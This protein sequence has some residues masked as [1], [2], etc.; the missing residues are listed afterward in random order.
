MQDLCIRYLATCEAI[1]L[2]TRQIVEAMNSRGHTIKA[3]FMSGGLVKNPV[4]MQLL[5]DVCSM[6]VQLPASAS[7]SVVLGSAMLGA[8]AGH[9]DEVAQGPITTQ[10]QASERARAMTHRL[11]DVMV[12]DAT[13]LGLT[14]Q[15]KMS[16]PGTTV[17]PRAEGKEKALLDAK[18]K[19]FVRSV[20][21]GLA[22]L[23]ARAD[24]MP[25]SVAEVD[26]GRVG[27]RGVDGGMLGLDVHALTRPRA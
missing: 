7:A 26:G 5:A 8:A 19:V 10:E 15:V 12:R 25:D 4:L 21:A 6:P 9:P 20:F 17:K 1:A 14:G 22:D 16:R 11:W 13:G 3:I 23:P 2:Q 18:Y 24:R 27:E